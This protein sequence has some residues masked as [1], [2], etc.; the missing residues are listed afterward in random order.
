LAFDT[1][2]Q[3]IS[4]EPGANFDK[5]E[6]TL[7]THGL[8]LPPYPAS[9]QY[10]TIGGAIANNSVGEKSVKYGSMKDY[11]QD[12]RV[13]L[14]NGEVIH[15]GPISKRELNKKLGQTTFEADIYRGID[16]LLEENS[17]LIKE[18]RSRMLARHSSVG[19]NIFDVK[20]KAGF[21]LTPLFVGSQGSLGI[22]TEANVEVVPHNPETKLMFI[23]LEKLSDVHLVL[24]TILQLKPSI[25]DMINK[26]AILQVSRLNPNQLTSLMENPAAE[27]HL[28]VE[29]DDKK[30]AVQKKALKKISKLVQ[31]VGGTFLVAEKIHEQDKIWKIR[32]S[33][34]TIMMQ[35][36]GQSKAIPL[37]EDVSIPVNGLVDFIH[38]VNQ[39]YSGVGLVP[40]MWGQ[41]GDGIVRMYPTLDLAQTGDRQRLFKIAD[42][43][44]ETV[45]QMGGSISAGA[46]DGRVR[47]QYSS[48][49]FGEELAMLM[50][51]IKKI[52]DPY[53]IL[54]NGVKTMG[55]AEMISLMRG[56]YNMAH[57]NEYLPR[58]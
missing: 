10:S 48:R 38:K 23:S 39:I 28:F 25:C 16:G 58:S 21:D 34:S 52:F 22:I 19:Y 29:F 13:V 6:Q 47:A 17:Q 14:A 9:K 11:V 30:D 37:A 27:I 50:L 42:S 36:N 55:R 26:S 45:V 33:V 20:T 46:G 5:L 49:I 53:G 24:P 41:A 40:A 3:F 56:E 1:K 4:V 18:F 43:V 57:R 32:H 15:T 51:K 31:K 7:L 35:S 54:N 2:K 44:Y 12:L 8:F